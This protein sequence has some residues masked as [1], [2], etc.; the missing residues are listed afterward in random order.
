[1]TKKN[2]KKILLALILFLLSSPGDFSMRAN[3]S[4]NILQGLLVTTNVGITI[5]VA[6]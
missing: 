4:A 5:S 2:I 6:F 1:M 3:E